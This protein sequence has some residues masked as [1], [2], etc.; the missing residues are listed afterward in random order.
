MPRHLPALLFALIALQ[1][2]CGSSRPRSRAQDFP[3]LAT[4]QYRWSLGL[5][6]DGNVAGRDLALLA[7]GDL[8]VVGSFE[9]SLSVGARAMHSAG[10]S[11]GFLARITPGGE[12]VWAERVGGPGS[13][14]LLAV[15]SDAGGGAAIAG[16]VAADARFEDNPLAPPTAT[17]PDPEGAVAFV[18]SIDSGGA[19]RWI[20]Y[21]DCTAYAAVVDLT[22][23]PDGSLLAAG[24]FNGTVTVGAHSLSSAGAQDVLAVRFA[25]DGNPLWARRAGGSGADQAQAVACASERVLLVGGFARRALFDGTQVEVTGRGQDAF[26][27]TL[28]LDGA[29]LGVASYGGDRDD[30]A[31]AVASDAEGGYCVAGSF[32]GTASFGGDDLDARGQSDVFLAC[33]A[34]DGTHRWSQSMGGNGSDELRAL[35]VRGKDLAIAGTFSGTGRFGG[36]ELT[37]AGGH[38]VF[39]AKLG[40]TGDA[41]WARSFGSAGQ[42]DIGGLAV[43]AEGGLAIAG[44]FSRRISFGGAELAARGMLDGFVARLMD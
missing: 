25:A 38:D 5:A 6:S 22:F 4:G 41:V 15:A 24:Y 12:T 39:V 34:R 31:F 44:T 1:L 19:L 8:L 33:Y 30:V 17:Q 42:E 32:G 27:A 11:D 20:R 14:A 36:Q 7:G 43:E 10:D 18:A 2:A 21:L 28:D 9:Q 16:L 23:A 3:S 26:I 40:L 37:S 35:D 29:V 13:D